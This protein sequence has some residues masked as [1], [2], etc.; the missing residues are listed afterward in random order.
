MAL[1]ET[2]KE[3][4][5]LKKLQGKAHTS[6]NKGLANEALS[7]GLTVSAKTVFSTDIPGSPTAT[8]YAVSGGSVQYV[9]LSA[10]FIA[11]SD[12]VAG[13]HAFALQLPDDYEAPDLGSG[14]SAANN[15]FTGKG[16]A[17]FEDETVSNATKGALQLVPPSYGDAY[18]AKPYMHVDGT[19]DPTQIPVLDARDWY[20]DYFNGILFQ[21]DLS[22]IHISEPTRPY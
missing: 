14:P 16:T 5:S 6:N 22:L 11:G 9:R 1:N 8:H 12:T 3:F 4:I 10:S 19:G 15:P 21:Q 13:R 7:S 18:E 20:I 17:P 2:S